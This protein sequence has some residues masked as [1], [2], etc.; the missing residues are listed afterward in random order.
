[1]TIREGANNLRPPS[2]SGVV[3]A[4]VLVFAVAVALASGLS[5]AVRGLL[6]VSDD[7]YAQLVAGIVGSTVSF[8]GVAL[9]GLIGLHIVRRDRFDQMDWERRSLAAALS[10]ECFDIGGV[11]EARATIMGTRLDEAEGEPVAINL[12]ELPYISTAIYEGNTARMGVLGPELAEQT[13][14]LYGRA[15][16]WKNYGETKQT[17]LRWEHAIKRNN[18]IA[19]M[20]K[21]HAQVLKVAAGGKV[22]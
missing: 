8:F 14:L 3:V 7:G 15:F 12:R 5:S 1:M 19:V 16:V 21:K 13:V 11:I 17:R 20:L 10:A 18:E 22:P 4:A 2:M 6:R 9:S